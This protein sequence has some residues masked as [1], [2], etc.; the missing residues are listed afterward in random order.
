LFGLLKDVEIKKLEFNTIVF[1]RSDSLFGKRVP[2]L[3]F[4]LSQV[5]PSLFDSYFLL[6]L[7]MVAGSL[8]SN[9]TKF[10][11]THMLALEP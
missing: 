7:S 4:F 11:V 5:I 6:M 9:S 2:V 10:R 3:H 1:I 8:V